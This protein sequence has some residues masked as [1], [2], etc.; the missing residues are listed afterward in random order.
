MT[1]RRNDIGLNYF[2]FFLFVLNQPEMGQGDGADFLE[3]TP[4][5]K[6]QSQSAGR[7]RMRKGK[8]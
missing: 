1:N 5:K 3:P 7:Q 4:S 8:S 6:H 2:S